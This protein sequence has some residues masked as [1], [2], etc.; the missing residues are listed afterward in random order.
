LHQVEAST[1]L[2]PIYPCVSHDEEEFDFD[3]EGTI[4]LS[5]AE[6]KEE[7]EIEQQEEEKRRQALLQLKEILMDSNL[8]SAQKEAEVKKVVE[9]NRDVLGDKF[10]FV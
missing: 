1:S 3:C 5:E 2:P 4:G 9:E 10:S 8:D 6:Q 7:E